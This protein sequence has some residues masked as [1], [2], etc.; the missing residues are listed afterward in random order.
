MPPPMNPH[1]PP[2]NPS[3]EPK[4]LIERSGF[5]TGGARP[6]PVARRK[7][8]KEDHGPAP[9]RPRPCGDARAQAALSPWAMF[10]SGFL[11][12]P[13]MVGSVIASTKTLQ[14]KMLEPRRL[15][16][17]QV[18][19]RIRPRRRHLLPAD[20]RPPAAPT[21]TLYR[22]RHQP[23]FHPTICA[24]SITDPRFVAVLGSAADVE[25]I[26]A[27][28]GFDHADYVLSGL[29]FSTLPPGVGAGDRR[30]DAPRAASPAARSWSISSAPRCSDF[31]TPHWSNIDHEIEWWRSRPATIS[32]RG[33]TTDDGSTA[34]VPCSFS[35]PK[36]S[37]RVTL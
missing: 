31:L 14:N 9:H 29:P 37:R 27:D 16:E 1:S 33:R 7:R 5:A 35:R 36:L 15:G 12:H 8:A 3:V 6:R 19:R 28:H 10:L 11:K 17:H 25:Q 4:S 2:C 24:S 34:R 18:V 20:P 22:D 26:V 21:A 23:R 32:G 13:V 30:G